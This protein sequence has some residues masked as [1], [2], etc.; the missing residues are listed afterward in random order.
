MSIN[1]HVL[2][3][4]LFKQIV[5]T[6]NEGVI[7]TDSLFKVEFVNKMMAGFLEKTENEI[8]G[9]PITDFI[10]EE[11]LLK[12]N[13]SKTSLP[14]KSIK[15]FEIRFILAKGAFT[16][17]L[18]STSA[19]CDNEGVFIGNLC[20]V[21]DINDRKLK[22]TLLSNISYELRSP[23]NGIMGFS[24]LLT[25]MVR[26]SEHSKMA[27]I[28]TASGKKLMT[29]LNAIMD[30]ADIDGDNSKLHFETHD[31]G[32]LIDNLIKRYFKDAQKKGIKLNFLL[33]PDH[34]A[35]IDKTFFERIIDSLVDNA[36]KFTHEGSVSIS[37]S[38][39]LNDN[40]KTI[41]VNVKDTGIGIAPENQRI[42]FNE[43]RQ[44]SVGF[45]R[46][47]EGTGI[48]LSLSKRM[49]LMMKGSIK[50]ESQ[51]GLGS[52]FSLLLPEAEAPKL[53]VSAVINQVAEQNPLEN[54]SDILNKPLILVVEDNR[55]NLELL[56]IYL[57]SYYQVDK[58]IDGL[59]AIRL[60]SSK[61]YDVILMDINLGIGM[62]GLRATK[63]IRNIPGYR[64]IPVI[65]VT[66]YTTR[67]D[68]DKLQAGG[69]N[70]YL[71][72]PFEKKKLLQLLA[73]VLS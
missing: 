18:I 61:Q 19:V 33:Q 25:E 68:K 38:V 13:Q 40:L 48:G 27:K 43:F 8:I 4:A 70:H 3:N 51:L 47:Y 17:G 44:V 63:E 50:V 46:E 2:S 54:P 58:A 6:A 60:T 36:I 32:E 66:G 20:M 9:H 49:A 52:T 24:E 28:I 31:V 71:A 23:L 72:K 65:A 39:G 34:Y 21:A 67:E 69:I 10:V 55:F 45:G 29:T 57:S 62:D 41:F 12:F 15:R 7:L 16:W 59:T 1:H 37:I 64:D 30:L 42:I 26:D 73:E 53:S 56:E 35:I 22:S 5:E 14:S 11:D